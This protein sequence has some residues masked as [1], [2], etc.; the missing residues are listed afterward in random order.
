M[1]TLREI[2]NETRE[3]V[4]QERMERMEKHTKTLTA[5]LHELRNE[6]MKDY[7]ATMIKDEVVAEPSYRKHGNEEIPPLGGQPD[8]VHAHRDAVQTLGEHGNE[9]RDQSRNG[10]I[11]RSG[12]RGANVEENELR[13]RLHNIEQERDQAAARD[14]GRALELGG[15]CDDWRR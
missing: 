2:A 7:E 10:R 1:I 13:L 14:P 9:G 12:T 8:G 5:I 11:R 6:R 15:K 4:M 3:K